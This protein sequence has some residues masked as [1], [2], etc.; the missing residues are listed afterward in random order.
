MTKLREPGVLRTRTGEILFQAVSMDT[1]LPELPVVF[2]E[3]P[4]HG[5]CSKGYL[6]PIG[7][8]PLI[9]GDN[10]KKTGIYF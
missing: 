9:L 4:L 6:N 5:K 10:G 2:P 1:P 7:L 8:R 3:I